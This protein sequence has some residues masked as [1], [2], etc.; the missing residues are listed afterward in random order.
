MANE[1]F[2]L[3]LI[4]KKNE[5]LRKQLEIQSKINNL[6]SNNKNSLVASYLTEKRNE[7]L[8]QQLSLQADINKLLDTNNLSLK[9]NSIEKKNEELLKQLNYQDKISN[10]LIKQNHL[11]DEDQKSFLKKND[12]SKKHLDLTDKIK[13]S[14]DKINKIDWEHNDSL[15]SKSEIF[16]IW[17]TKSAKITAGIWLI[18]KAYNQVFNTIQKFIDLII[19]SDRRMQSRTVFKNLLG[20]KKDIDEQLKIMREMS[21]YAI[22][23]TE[24]I[25]KASQARQFG[26]TTDIAKLL[27][28]ARDLAYITGRDINQVFDEMVT[29]IGRQ[30]YKIADNMNIVMRVGDANKKFAE[31]LGKSSSDLTAS[32]RMQSFEMEFM[33]RASENIERFGSAMPTAIERIGRF[34]SVIQDLKISIADILKPLTNLSVDVAELLA[35]MTTSIAKFA[36]SKN[37]L[38]EVRKE[39]NSKD[40]AFIGSGG[41]LSSPMKIGEMK[42]KF[43]AS[44]FLNI[45]EDMIK[46]IDMS[47][48]TKDISPLTK[49]INSFLDFIRNSTNAIG[50]TLKNISLV[51]DQDTYKKLQ[52]ITF[53]AVGAD[54]TD[55]FREKSKIANTKI[56]RSLV[57]SYGKAVSEGADKKQLSEI[58][59]KIRNIYKTI[60]FNEDVLND[61]VREAENYRKEGLAKAFY[62]IEE[63]FRKAK[64]NRIKVLEDEKI[65]IEKKAEIELENLRNF[66]EYLDKLEDYYNE[67]QTAYEKYLDN[68]SSFQDNLFT[69]FKNFESGIEKSING[70]FDK[71][72][73]INERL[74]NFFS[75]IGDSILDGITGNFSKNIAQAFTKEI[76]S[77]YGGNAFSGMEGSPTV[78]INN[79]LGNA[80]DITTNYDSKNN[81]INATI[82]TKSKNSNINRMMK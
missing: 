38:M 71:E 37:L 2:D 59:G 58:E 1:L 27:K 23:D 82:Q 51:Y 22:P 57:E 13:K 4:Q 8:K 75:G 18:Q 26:L 65:L 74:S 9:D 44:K 5:L 34:K 33:L 32:E 50:N 55:V 21:G 40:Q 49:G 43:E 12:L 61:V 53:E 67:N 79:M 17:L 80:L 66:E 52:S 48:I 54:F 62:G 41:E 63:E 19:L 15:K 69:M 16:D 35:K 20:D 6:L 25:F 73:S 56:I 47:L 29:A 68:V 60:Y 7:L 77:I 31:K 64:E 28:T 24:L 39:I 81:S 72:K 42:Q 10:I 45:S 30:S 3:N 11:S 36:G 78:N 14:K 76:A 70:L 46:N